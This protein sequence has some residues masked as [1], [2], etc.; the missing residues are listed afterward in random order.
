[1]S[2][3]LYILE[4]QKDVEYGHFT[5]ADGQISVEAETYEEAVELALKRLPKSKGKVKEW[6]QTSYYGGGRSVEKK[7]E[8]A[9][10]LLDCYD[11]QHASYI[12]N[13]QEINVDNRSTSVSTSM[14]INHRSIF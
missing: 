14:A 9:F 3:A 8:H 10:R 1:M 11:Q 6:E 5:K 7:Y 12:P 2:K 4:Y 13:S